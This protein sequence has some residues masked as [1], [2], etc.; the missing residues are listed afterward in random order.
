MGIEN[1]AVTDRVRT[2]VCLAKVFFCQD[3]WEQPFWE[4]MA[5]VQ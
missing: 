2:I 5:V 3:E 4:K 1:Q